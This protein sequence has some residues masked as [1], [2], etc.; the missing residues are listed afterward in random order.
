MKKYNIVFVSAD[1]KTE[2]VGGPFEE[3]KNSLEYVNYIIDKNYKGEKESF[4]KVY[5]ESKNIITVYSIG[6]ISKSLYGKYYIL[7]YEDE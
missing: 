2:I 4:Y 3:Y 1:Y 7:E 5:F 6:Y